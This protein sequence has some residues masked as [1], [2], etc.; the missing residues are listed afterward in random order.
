MWPDHCVQGTKGAEIERGVKTRLE[1]LGATIVRK[2]QLVS[3]LKSCSDEGGHQ[4]IICGGDSKGTD[5]DLD[6]YSSFAIPLTA[7]DQ[8]TSP[9]TRILFGASVNNPPTVSN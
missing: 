3:V 5:V 1:K 6:A 8:M 2:V 7:Q 9:V 4:L